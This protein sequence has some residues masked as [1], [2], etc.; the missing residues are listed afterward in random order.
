MRQNTH[1]EISVGI[2]GLGTVGGGTLS[3][4]TGESSEEIR[5][6]VGASITVSHVATRTLKPQVT[7][8]IACVGTDPFSVVSDPNVDIV[9]ETMGGYDP[10]FE[11]IKKALF[12]KKHVV[13]A[14]KALIAE[15]GNEL[16]RFAQ[17][18]GAVS[19]THLT[20][21]TKA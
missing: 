20:L 1:K 6:R 18:N 21:P 5:H 3:L 9:I 13:T 4:L 2:C 12:N 17:D 7:E 11:L 16:F 10:A 15:R 8:G 14:N 19:Y